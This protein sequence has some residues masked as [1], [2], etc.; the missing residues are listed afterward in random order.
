MTSLVPLK[1]AMMLHQLLQLQ[2]RQKPQHKKLKLPKEKVTTIERR[3]G[4]MVKTKEVIEVEEKEAEV[5]EVEAGVAE[6]EVVEVE[7]QISMKKDLKRLLINKIVVEEEVVEEEA[8]E[9]EEEEVEEIEVV[10][11]IPHQVKSKQVERKS[12]LEVVDHKAQESLLMRA[13][14]MRQ[15]NN[16]LSKGLMIIQPSYEL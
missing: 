4:K 5:E 1:I 16:E 12:E 14:K 13:R 6:E 3:N 7:T 9:T 11:Q 2:K 15:P 10:D 8:E